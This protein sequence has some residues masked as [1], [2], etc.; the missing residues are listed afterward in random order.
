MLDHTSYITVICVLQLWQIINVNHHTV[1][2]CFI[3][4]TTIPVCTRTQNIL[5]G[6]TTHANLF[7][8][9]LQL[10]KKHPII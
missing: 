2:S 8:L 3:V 10:L 6:T 9:F 5:K 7:F 1:D 4:L